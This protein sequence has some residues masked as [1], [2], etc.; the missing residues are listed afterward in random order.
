MANRKNITTRNV[1]KTQAGKLNDGT[2]IS[3]ETLCEWFDIVEPKTEGMS[4]REARKA[5]QRYQ[6]AKLAAY[7]SMNNELR[8]TGRVIQ[9]TKEDYIVRHGKTSL[10]PVIA[11]IGNRVSTLEE[12]KRTLKA[13]TRG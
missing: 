11:S 7:S 13:A 5:L 1:I 9:Q 6:F 4:F 10:A 8:T 2:R 3:E 12:N